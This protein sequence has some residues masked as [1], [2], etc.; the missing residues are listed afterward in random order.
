MKIK[1]CGLTQKYNLEA[2]AGLGTDRLGLIFYP[3]SQR[4][5]GNN[6]DLQRRCAAAAL[7][8]LTGIFVDQDEAY[9]REIT[10]AFKLS[11]IQLHGAEPPAFCERIGALRPVVKAFAVHG[12]FDFDRLERYRHCCN[13]FLFDTP[14]AGFGGSGRAFDW[15]LLQDKDIPLPFWLAGGIGP[16]DTAKVKAF[17][18]PAWAG[19]DL[20]SRFESAPGVKDIA[21]L[22]TFITQ[23]RR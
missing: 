6:T 21:L 14:D 16:G 19:I 12:Q 20:N 4:Y 2:V 8:G 13:A 1:V 11:Y 3:G 7:P 17:K 9:I 22:N 18:H 23:L 5:A 15:R 10:V